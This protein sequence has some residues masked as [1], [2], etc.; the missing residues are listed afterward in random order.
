MILTCHQCNF[1]PYEGVIEKIRKSDIFVAL[2]YVQF[3]RG[4]Y[5][6]RFR[7]HDRWYTMSVNQRL[8]PLVSK[9]YTDLNDWQRIKRRLPQY[10]EILDEFDEDVEV[11]CNV[12]VETNF[13]IIE[14]ICRK[15]GIHTMLVRD[16]PVDEVD[17]SA[18]LAELCRLHGA[19]TYLS[20]PSGLKYLNCDEFA[21]RGVL[22]SFQ[23]NNHRGRAALELLS[24]GP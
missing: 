14:R 16:V 7:L 24:E 22:V 9:M 6:N 12:L 20:G 5:H 11:G 19:K 2:G 21:R 15:L 17:A 8:E 3:S 13:R 23:P 10:A 18:R 1:F 4:N